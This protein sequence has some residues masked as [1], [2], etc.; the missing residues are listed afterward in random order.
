M[1]I[2]GMLQ[3]TV[4]V[5][6]SYVLSFVRYLWE[7]L[8]NIPCRLKCRFKRYVSVKQNTVYWWHLVLNNNSKLS[9]FSVKEHHIL[10][11]AFHV[12]QQHSLLAA[13][14]VKQQNNLTTAF[15]VKQQQSLLAAFDVKQQT[16]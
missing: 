3:Y 10:L 4:R 15:G 5:I 8:G 6:S 2:R 9:A 13:F 14:D 7:F 16:I 12:K 1:I 11:A